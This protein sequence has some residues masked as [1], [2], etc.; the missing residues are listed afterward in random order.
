MPT[1]ACSRSRSRCGSTSSRWWAIAEQLRNRAHRRRLPGPAE[2]LTFISANAMDGNQRDNFHQ[3]PPGRDRLRPT[4]ICNNSMPTGTCPRATYRLHRRP[5]GRTRT[6][7]QLVGVGTGQ[8]PHVQ[9][10]AAPRAHPGQP[11]VPAL[12][13]RVA[14]GDRRART[15]TPRAS[16]SN[17]PTTSTGRTRR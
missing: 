16:P 15:A 14:G 17:G 6:T 5:T 8:E 2:L 9:P 7:G 1:C 10:A 4:P 11:A 13:G 3:R 12:A